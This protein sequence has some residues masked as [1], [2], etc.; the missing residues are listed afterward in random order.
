MKKRS[1]SSSGKLVRSGD[2]VVC[3]KCGGH[4]TVKSVRCN[5]GGT[6][7]APEFIRELRRINR[8]VSV[9]VKKAHP[10][11]KNPDPV[12]ALYKWW[13]GGK[14]NFNIPT[15]SQWAAIR[16][17]IDEQL[18]PILGWVSPTTAEKRIK[19]TV[20]TV[21]LISLS[22]QHPDRF[23]KLVEALSVH[24]ELPSSD[25]GNDELYRAIAE[26]ISQFDKASVERVT[27]IVNAFKNEGSANVKALDEVLADW[28]VTQITS[29][30][31]ETRRRLAMIELLRES[32]KN[33]KTFE[34]RGD[35]SIHSIL[36]QDLWLLDESYWMIQ[37]N[38]TLKTFIGDSLAEG[39][40]K[41]YGNKRPDFACG[42]LGSELV[43]VELKRPK[44]RLA[45]ED[46]NQLEEYLAIS[47]KYSTRFK[48]HKAYLMGS[49]ISEEVRTYLR[50]R[51]GFTVLSYWE[52]LDAAEKRYKEFL[53][54]REKS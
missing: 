54:Y 42:S 8:F 44:H 49:T 25:E 18:G 10:E 51:R 41:R 22:K 13:P 9:Q 43:I 12:I 6:K 48:S 37:S 53:K 7:F 39:D 47:E 21:D 5:C 35:N 16:Q 1:K 32:L 24:I 28:S 50:F 2:Y 17:I 30:L 23:A 14:A 38:K 46:L 11:S 19:Q 3:D 40:M 26:L 15:S 34:L 29:V 36:E 45:K 20:P 27:R 52:V 31:R 33:D 4:N